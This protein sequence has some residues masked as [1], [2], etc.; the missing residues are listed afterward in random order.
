MA[1]TRV[2]QA[3]ADPGGGVTGS[4]GQSFSVAEPAV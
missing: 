1:T 3:R 2:R 4:S